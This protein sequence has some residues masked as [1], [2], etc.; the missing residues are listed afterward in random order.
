MKI[1]KRKKI[2]LYGGA[3]LITTALLLSSCINDVE[4]ADPGSGTSDKTLTLTINTGSTAENAGTRVYNQSSD[5]GTTTENTIN[6]VTVGVFGSDNNVKII[7]EFASGDL[8][9]DT[10]NIA[11]LTSAS[12]AP[13]DQVLVAVN[14]PSGTVR[15]ARYH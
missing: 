14:A 11:T 10:H 2:N 9:G 4:L 13:D 7:K 3:A 8:T 6:R 1:M 15:V 12:L 5:P